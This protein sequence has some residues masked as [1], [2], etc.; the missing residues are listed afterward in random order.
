MAEWPPK[1]TIRASVSTMMTLWRVINAIT[2]HYVVDCGVTGDV[3]R[4]ITAHTSRMTYCNVLTPRSILQ[5]TRKSLRIKLNAPSIE[6]LI[7]PTDWIDRH[8]FQRHKR[9][10]VWVKPCDVTTSRDWLNPAGESNPITIS[11]NGG[12]RCQ[13]RLYSAEF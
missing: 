1:K 3:T 12:A 8:Y 7:L 2:L 13:H 11:L 9:D 6:S 10:M 5:G 4:S